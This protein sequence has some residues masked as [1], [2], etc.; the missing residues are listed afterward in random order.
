MND[1]N[2]ETKANQT[3]LFR[4]SFFRPEAHLV[5]QDGTVFRAEAIGHVQEV[6]TGEVVFHT[7]MSGYQE[8]MTDP[9]YAGQIITFTYPHIGSYG[10]NTSDD[11]SR[12]IFASG[13]I[14]RDYV[15]E[16]SNHQATQSLASWLKKQKIMGLTGLDTRKLTKHIREKGS[17]AA[18]FGTGSIEELKSAAKSAK[19]T[20]GI[21]LVDTVTCA[22]NYSVGEGKKT[23]VAF[24]FG[25]K[26]SIIDQLT[27]LGK[28]V[29]VPAKTSAKEV[30]AMKPD[31]VF[32]SNGPGDPEAVTYA[33]KTIS[34]LLGK[35]PVFGICLGHQLLC[36]ALSAKTKKLKFGHHGGNHPVKNLS[37]AK[38]EITSQNH[39]YEVDPNTLPKNVEVTHTNLND[40]VN[41]GVAAA[42]SYA[43]SVQYHPEAGPGPHDARYLFEQFDELMESYAKKK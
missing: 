37:T 16:H 23:I 10:I 43:F 34:Q 15:V 5:L 24:D 38:I 36:I 6:A 14:M 21:D 13:M 30:L 1:Q 28:V 9:S 42:D 35:V 40:G 20:D 3:S 4:G 7:G 25:I 27:T 19:N 2:S 33:S 18:A 29:V 8:I 12:R 11:E 17:M 41:E 22:E 31:G 39:N 32:L 26:Q